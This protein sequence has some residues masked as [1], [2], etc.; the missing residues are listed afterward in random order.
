MCKFL[1][2]AFNTYQQTGERNKLEK[3]NTHSK[4]VLSLAEELNAKQSSGNRNSQIV[5]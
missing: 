4:K 5:R 1:H 3:R 2:S